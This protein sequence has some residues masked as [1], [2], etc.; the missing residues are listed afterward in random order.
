MAST[1]LPINGKSSEDEARL[2]NHGLT[3]NSGLVILNLF[4]IDTKREIHTRRE[5][6]LLEDNNSK[7]DESKHVYYCI[8]Y[9]CPECKLIRISARVK[10]GMSIDTNCGACNVKNHISIIDI[11]NFIDSRKINSIELQ[12]CMFLNSLT[13]E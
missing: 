10:I 5:V 1:D 9:M 6:K 8:E 7:F 3:T 4:F 2:R 12:S 13:R 11:A